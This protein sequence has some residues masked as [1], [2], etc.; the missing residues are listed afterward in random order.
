MDFNLDKRP[1]GPYNVFVRLASQDVER[2]R[3]AE[4]D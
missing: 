4:L 1:T 3:L 2:A